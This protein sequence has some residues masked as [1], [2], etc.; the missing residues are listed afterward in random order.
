MM[1]GILKFSVGSIREDRDFAIIAPAHG[2]LPAAAWR[3]SLSAGG[4][5]LACIDSPVAATMVRAL[6]LAEVR[7]G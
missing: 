5:L 7:F 4:K 6:R 1:M 2:T 3:R